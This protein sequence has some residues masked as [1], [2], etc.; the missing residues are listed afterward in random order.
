M[1]V[2]PADKSL[3][4]WIWDAACSIRGA[5]DA[6]KYKDYILPLIFTKRLCD[7]FDDELNRI[8]EE[9]GGRAKAFK[10]VRHDKKLVRFHLPLEP[11]SPDDP[12]WSVIRTL[13]AK[14][15]EQLTTHLRAIADANPLL[16]GIL[17]RVD[18]NATTHGSRDLDDDRLSALIEAISAKRLGLRDVEPDIIGRSYE[19]L[20]RKFAE[21]AGRSGGEQYTPAEVGFVMARIMEPE[22]GMDC[23]DPT[24]GSAGLLIKLDLVLRER[25]AAKK[26]LP[27][28]S[29]RGA[30]VEVAKHAPL[31][32]HGQEYE[33]SSWA[34]ANMNMIIHD[35]EGRIEIGNTFKNPK[36][37]AGNR[38]QTFDRVVANPMWN[39]DWFKEQDYEADPFDRFPKGAGF[40]GNK[41]DWGW[42]QHILASLKAPSTGSGQAGGRAAVVL[43][44]GAASRGSGNANSNKE[45]EVRQWFVAQ[46]VIE[47]VI[48]LP[49]NLFYNTT[50]PGIIIVLN[51]AKLKSRAGKMLL[52]NASRDF[53]KGDPKNYLPEEAVTRIAETFLAWKEVEKFSRI[54]GTDEIAKND[55]NISPS[56]YIHVGT[57][58]EYRPLVEVIEELDV[59]EEDACETN[60]TLRTVLSKLTEL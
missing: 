2:T 16:K 47:G 18:F 17:D 44:T 41:A 9:V 52:L 21:G 23:Y 27:S 50:A 45:K 30:G 12:V 1:P 25:M 34:M 54:L 8:A 22:P 10:L 55:Y 14:I 57:A 3:E 35:L 46:D 42:M 58:D 49:E 32:L 19:Y 48:Y 37:R 60:K 13:S 20:I 24:C 28:P 36:F 5:K 39:Q 7:V 33:P 53:V 40:P 4:N 6:G 56:R 15:G 11:K 51:R 59:L 43:D 38:L 26:K 29:G 31:K